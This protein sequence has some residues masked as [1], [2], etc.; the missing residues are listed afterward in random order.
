MVKILKDQSKHS[1]DNVE[2]TIFLIMIHCNL[3]IAY[4]IAKP[5]IKRMESKRTSDVNT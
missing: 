5:G 1:I 3:M 2:N 4:M